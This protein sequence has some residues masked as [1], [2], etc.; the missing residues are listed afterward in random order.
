MQYNDIIKKFPKQRKELPEEYKA[1]Y[2]QYYKENRNGLT[3][4]SSLSQKVESWL[5]KKVAKTGESS[6]KTLEIGAGTLNQLNYERCQIYDIVEP[7]RSLFENSL[8]KKCIRNIYDD[9]TEVPSDEKYDRITSIACFEHICNLP[10]V[11]EKASELLNKAGVLAVSIPNQGYFLWKFG[12]TMTTGREFKKRFGLDYDIIMNYEHVNSADEI[13]IILKHYFENVK[14]SFF[15][16]GKNFS[17]YRYYE[18][19]SPKNTSVLTC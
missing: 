13:E 6:K 1:I 7:F 14:Y 4:A 17:L 16:I 12:Y 10:E 3:K 8:S 18:C 11:V 19:S 5:H 2:E 9:I 15:G